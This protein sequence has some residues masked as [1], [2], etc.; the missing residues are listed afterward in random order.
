[1]LSIRPRTDILTPRSPEKQGADVNAI[2]ALVSR[3]LTEVTLALFEA[4]EVD[5]TPL[6]EDTVPPSRPYACVGVLS[7]TSATLGGSLLLMLER[8]VIERSYTLPNPNLPDWTGELANQL[9]GRLKNALARFGVN[10]NLSIPVV[11][12]GT[13][14]SMPPSASPIHCYHRYDSSYGRVAVRLN[15]FVPQGVDIELIETEDQ[16]L[17]EGRGLLFFSLRP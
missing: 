4:Y 12:S 7:F 3:L 11:V 16:S 1:M 5:I 17:A 9:V 14:L 15:V 6:G 13:G 8:G 10:V 2:M